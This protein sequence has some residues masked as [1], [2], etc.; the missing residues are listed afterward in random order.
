MDYKAQLFTYHLPYPVHH[1]LEIPIMFWLISV[2]VRVYFLTDTAVTW[3]TGSEMNRTLYLMWTHSP[4]LL[5][6]M[7]SVGVILKCVAG[8]YHSVQNNGRCRLQQRDAGDECP[9]GWLALADTLNRR[10]A[11]ASSPTVQD[12]C[13]TAVCLPAKTLI[14]EDHPFTSFLTKQ[15]L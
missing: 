9:P 6:Y 7:S 8:A 4:P 11:L 10:S 1:C 15:Q 5:Q 13:V 14:L 2:Y 3:L 12:A